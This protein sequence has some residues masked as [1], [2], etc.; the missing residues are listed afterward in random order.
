[1]AKIGYLWLN[2]G[3][4]EDKQIVSRDWVEKSVRA[5]MDT[6]DNDD[7]G[8]GWWVSTDEPVSYSAI[9]RGGQ[10]IIVVPAW[11]LIVVT[12]GGGFDF[13]EIEP[14]LIETIVDMDRTLPANS[15][16]ARCSPQHHRTTS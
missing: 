1:M 15:A 16:G 13:D 9:G 12:T 8:Y 3:Q 2:K 10:R 7:Y 11:N 4:W 5:Q 6:G 14:L